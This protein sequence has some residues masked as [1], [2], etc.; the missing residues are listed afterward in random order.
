MSI[1]EIEL[2]MDK[3]EEFKF[4]DFIGIENENTTSSEYEKGF[5]MGVGLCLTI[6][7]ELRDEIKKNLIR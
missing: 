4:E 5:N 6:L 7:D 3:F 1:E 2:L